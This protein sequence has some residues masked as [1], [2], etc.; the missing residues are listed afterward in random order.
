MESLL[1]IRRL[2]QL[3]DITEIPDEILDPEPER[4]NRLGNS[5]GG[6][7]QARVLDSHNLYQNPS[8]GRPP[9]TS[10]NN[11]SLRSARHNLLESLLP[12][13]HPAMDSNPS[14]SAPASL[15]AE[16]SDVQTPSPTAGRSC[17][18]SITRSSSATDIP[19]TTPAILPPSVTSSPVHPRSASSSVVGNPTESRSRQVDRPAG[20]VPP[21]Q[22][23]T[24][25]R[26]P[27]PVNR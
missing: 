2:Q 25:N 3:S 5:A 22:T 15:R 17:N 20:L 4:D 11:H 9:P 10:L 8:P 26:K 7:S 24:M 16:R 19:L 6:P 27:F 13:S 12:F 23:G 14:A 1:T 21:V 18:V